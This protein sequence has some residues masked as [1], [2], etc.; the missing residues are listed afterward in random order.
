MRLTF[1]ASPV[2]F[3]VMDFKR[4]G[5]LLWLEHLLYSIKH[6]GFS[7]TCSMGLKEWKK[8]RELGIKTFGAH[9]AAELSIEADSKMGGH[10]YQP[11]SSV[12]FERAM[13]ALPFNFGDKVF[14]DIGSGKGR[15]L[16][17]AAEAGYK[18]V[19]GVEYATELNDMAHVNIAKV[20]DRFP[21]TEFVLEEGDALALD[22]AEEVD[23]I[24]LFNPFDEEALT[25]LMK[26]VK[27]SF[28]RTKPI[29]LVYVHPVHC[30]VIEAQLG[31]P[32]EVVKNWKGI[33][34]VAVFGNVNR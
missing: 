11:S 12:I 29:Y 34:D 31:N 24:Y 3:E 17:L 23:V 21:N 5:K 25:G 8:E 20:Q 30:K 22:I 13:H 19:I 4:K 16:V 7:S 6:R 2:N 26:K 9:A 14:L 33:P 15:A 28:E 18:K 32:I 10:L 27:P 1:K